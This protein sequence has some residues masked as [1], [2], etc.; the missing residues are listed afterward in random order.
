MTTQIMNGVLGEMNLSKGPVDR[1][2]EHLK[3]SN[4]RLFVRACNIMPD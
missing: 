4:N 1:T 2:K 3:F